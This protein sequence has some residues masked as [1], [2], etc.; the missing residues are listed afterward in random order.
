M[1]KPA[2]TTD[3]I[4]ASLKKRYAREKRFKLYGILA[5]MTGFA[6]LVILLSDIIIKGTPAFTQNFIQIELDLS[7]ETLD[8]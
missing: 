2:D 7:A 3:I 8:I 1:N 6:F 4:K 5:V